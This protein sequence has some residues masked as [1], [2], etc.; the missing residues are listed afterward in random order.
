MG[1]QRLGWVLATAPKNHRLGDRGLEL[2]TGTPIKAYF[3]E[4]AGAKSGAIGVQLG[5][6]FAGVRENW[7]TLPEEIKD[8]IVA[9]VKRGLNRVNTRRL[10]AEAMAAIKGG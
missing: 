4:S 8:V 1:K 7:A 5:P 10:A 3:S 6:Q 9:T 2:S